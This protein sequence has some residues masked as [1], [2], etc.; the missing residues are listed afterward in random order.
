MIISIVIL[1]STLMVSLLKLLTLLLFLL[2]QRRP[3]LKEERLMSFLLPIMLYKLPSEQSPQVP[4]TTMYYS[5]NNL[6]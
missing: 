5:H 3:L 2:T 4:R 6:E 1:V